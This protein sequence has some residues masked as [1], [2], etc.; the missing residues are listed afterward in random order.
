MSEKTCPHCGHTKEVVGGYYA[1][2]FTADGF[3][4]VCK[5]CHKKHMKDLRRDDPAVRERDR[6]RAATRGRV[7][8]QTGVT[9][10]WREKNPDAHLA[11]S[12]VGYALRTKKLEKEPCAI[13][14]STEHI[15]AHHK[16]YSKPLEVVW[17]CARCHH[18][19]HAIFPELEGANK[20]RP[21]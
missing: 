5:D 15:H 13:C 16:D 4:G 14:S 1:H 20:K 2:P 9:K 17:L 7:E 3:M 6:K 19:L 11:H 10:A 8:R 12:A 21:A 18:R